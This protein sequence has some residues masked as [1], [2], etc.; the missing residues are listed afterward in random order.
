MRRSIVRPNKIRA[1][2]SD[3]ARFIRE[4]ASLFPALWKRTPKPVH[5]TL[6]GVKLAVD[7]CKSR[8]L[9]SVQAA[10]KSF[11]KIDDLR[12]KSGTVT[13]CIVM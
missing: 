1:S 5:R 6:S 12:C 4:S 10:T 3:A 7:E 8:A 13:L 11:E 2:L 9:E